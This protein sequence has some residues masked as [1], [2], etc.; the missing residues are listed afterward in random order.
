MADQLLFLN[1]IE[2][3]VFTAHPHNVTH[4]LC[5][6]G[7]MGFS[8]QHVRYNIS[9]GDYAIFP[10][11]MWPHGFLVSESAQYIAMT[12]PESF[13]NTSMIKSDY[14]IIGHLSLIQNPVMTLDG[15][16]FENFSH[17][18]ERMRE[19]SR[20]PHLFREEL[21]QALLKA[22]VLDLFNVHARANSNLEL[23]SR[24][25]TIMR[26]FISQLIAGDYIRFR[27]VD[28]YAGTLCVTP[29][30]LT[31]ISKRFSRQPASYWIDHFTV[32]ELSRMLV[33][34]SLTLNDIAF[35]MNFSSLS[36]LSRYVSK[37]LG[38]SPSEFR[39]ALSHK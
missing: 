20:S 14:G 8:L 9:E 21:I 3:F 2:D 12:F 1:N 39:K 38:A 33:D 23:S 19:R 30:Y 31:E 28:Y 5:T 7:T 10:S 37:H 26:Q 35:S 4:I 36:H 29:H 11:G 27:N 22:H 34:K 13:V 18:M 25:A 24:P 32:R 16:D 15:S 17:D 6:S